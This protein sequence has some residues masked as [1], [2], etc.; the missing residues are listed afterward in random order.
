LDFVF[1]QFLTGLASAS[2]LFLVAS[3]LTLIFGVTRIV[4]FAH[5]SLYML[6]AYVAYSLTA[7]LQG[8]LG[9]FA[10]F[11]GGVVLAALAV[12]L[13]GVAIEVLILRRIYDSPELFQLLAT[14]GV[15]LI[16]QDVALTVWGPEDLLGPRAP[17]L[18]G[19]VQVFGMAVPEY[20]FALIVIGPVVLAGLWAALR[21][22]RWGVLVRAATEDREMTGALGVDQARLF[23][24]VFFVGSVLAGLGGAL[25]LPREPASLGMDLGIIAEVFV[26]T[27]VGGMGSI[28][29]AFVAAVLIGEL[30][31]FGIL[32]FP[33]VTIVLVF[34]FMA[35]V[36]VLRPWGLFGRPE[37]FTRAAAAVASEPLRPLPRHGRW[38]AVALVAALAASPLVLGPYAVSVLTE[39]LIFAL[40]AVSLH[41]LAGIGGMVSFGHAA[42]F[43]LGAY[44]AGLAVRQMG[45]DPTLAIAAG[46]LLAAAGAALFGLVGV[47]LSGIYLAMLTLAFAQIG[48]AIAFQWVAVTGGDNGLLGI[49]PPAWAASPER[50]LWVVLALAGL[51]VWALRQAAHS[52]FG[53]GLRACRDSVLRAAAVGIDVRRQRWLAFVLA[54]AGAGLAGGLHA[55]FKGSVSPADL[56]IPV[57][58]DAL[59]MILLGGIDTLS[60]PIVGA[61]LYKIARI[62][63]TSWTDY[64]R[65][66][67]GCM[68]VAVVVLFPRGI[69]GELRARFGGRGGAA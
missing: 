67:L 49:W 3:G 11:W 25:Q 23:T 48:F 27:V 38:A 10:G 14:F 65:L 58:V 13:I 60:G 39:V 53:Y 56:A 26:V 59:V 18:S 47:G 50:F 22:T 32:V 54:G 28:V 8:P 17:G 30:H 52:P 66:V 41:L 5:G 55:F 40:F 20:D 34:L 37:R 42:F 21:W 44:G 19:A 69:V 68:I 35:V 1:V 31:A 29:G 61:A 51:G 2:S 57:S 46:V 12:G 64:W 36:L 6:G 63:I 62:V 4:N 45:L 16:V 9:A 24:G 15:V 43:G 33:Q 7:W